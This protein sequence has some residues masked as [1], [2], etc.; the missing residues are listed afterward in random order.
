MIF[1]Q[2]AIRIAK[3]QMGWACKDN[4]AAVIS[5]KK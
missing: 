5:K 2:T 1:D 3:D 4:T